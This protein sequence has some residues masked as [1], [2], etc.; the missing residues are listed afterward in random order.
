MRGGK[1]REERNLPN[2]SIISLTHLEMKPVKTGWVV[3]GQSK[4]LPMSMAFRLPM[5]FHRIPGILNLSLIDKEP[6]SALTKRK[7]MKL[8]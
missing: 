5:P 1:K 2:S 7:D 6:L 4:T 8:D 3:I